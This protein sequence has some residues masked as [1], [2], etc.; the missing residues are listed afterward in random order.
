MALELEVTSLD[1]VPEAI[2]G[3]YVKK[4]D[5]KFRLNVNGVEDVSGLKSALD[6]T[7]SELREYKA[8]FKDTGLTAADIGKLVD[9]NKALIETTAKLRDVQVS[10]SV[11][12]ALMRAK[13]IPTGADL[14]PAM[15]QKRVSIE[16][17]DG[18]DVMRISDAEGR[19]MQGAG[20]DGL[21]VMDDLIRQTVEKY[22][23]LFEGRGIGGGG[24]TGRFGRNPLGPKT[25]MRADFDRLSPADKMD[26]MKTGWNVVD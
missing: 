6:R 1:G 21:A 22:P 10:S 11:S 17:V 26:R 8:A 18:R 9:S 4:P 20:A 19:P 13:V 12:L 25:I 2:R 16:A 14:L 3:E 23:D 24:S 7:K 15:L 5:G